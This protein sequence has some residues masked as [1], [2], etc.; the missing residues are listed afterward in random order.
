[1]IIKKL[2]FIILASVIFELIAFGYTAI[3]GDNNE[4]IANGGSME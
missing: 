1:V 2:K 3:V 4:T